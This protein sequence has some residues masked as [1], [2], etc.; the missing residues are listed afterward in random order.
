MKEV[1]NLTKGY[2][3][4]DNLQALIDAQTGSRQ[5]GGLAQDTMDMCVTFF[6]RIVTEM[7]SIVDWISLWMT[8][9]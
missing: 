4:L 9:R 1:L 3:R 5:R 7:T 8:G 2:V 6:L